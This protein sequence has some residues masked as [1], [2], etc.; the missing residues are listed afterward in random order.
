MIL[1]IAESIVA[2]ALAGGGKVLVTTCPKG[3]DHEI[4]FHD[5]THPE[6]PPRRVSGRYSSEVLAVSPDE[7]LVA[8]TTGGGLV[9]LFD[10]LKGVMVANLQGHL[11]AALGVAFSPDGRRLI[12]SYGG[13]EGIKLWDVDTH[14]ELLTLNGFLG[15]QCFRAHWGSDG[16]VILAEEPWQAWRAPSWEEIAAA[17]TKDPQP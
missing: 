14:Q 8:S 2:A 15:G 11:N 3:N 9:R 16:E 10:P 7:R 13:R 6:L 17:E 4:A 5:L 1:A 12:S